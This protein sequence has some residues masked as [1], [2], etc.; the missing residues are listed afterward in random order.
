MLKTQEQQTAGRSKAVASVATILESM[1]PVLEFKSYTLNFLI[2]FVNSSREYYLGFPGILNILLIWC[3][4]CIL[5]EIV[6]R[7]IVCTLR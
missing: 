4:I 7:K 2:Y 6:L 3:S 5:I 1:N